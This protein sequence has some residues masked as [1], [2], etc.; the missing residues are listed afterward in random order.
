M[1]HTDLQQHEQVK[2]SLSAASQSGH[3]QPSLCPEMKER[4]KDSLPYSGK[5]SQIGVKYD[6]HGENFRKLLTFPTP[7]DATPPNF[8]EKTFTNSHKTAKFTKVSHYTVYKYISLLAKFL[9]YAG[10]TEV[11]LQEITEQSYKVMQRITE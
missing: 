2:A 1:P 10:I 7:K 8:T 6:F 9:S 3:L 11:K 5:L 4:S